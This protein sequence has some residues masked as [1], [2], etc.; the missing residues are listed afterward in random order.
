MNSNGL[1]CQGSIRKFQSKAY[2]ILHGFTFLIWHSFALILILGFINGVA[3]LFINCIAS[4]FVV[5]LTLLLLN[6]CT[7]FLGYLLAFRLTLWFQ[8]THG[9]ASIFGF[10]DQFAFFLNGGSWGWGSSSPTICLRVFRW[11]KWTASRCFLL[12]RWGC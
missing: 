6:I 2:R 9:A 8:K 4:L 10:S 7:S 5:S 3:F 1:L 12:W 11:K